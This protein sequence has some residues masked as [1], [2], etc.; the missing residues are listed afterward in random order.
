MIDWDTFFA[1][2]LGASAGLTGL[3]FVGISINMSQ[4]IAFPHL[5]NR[6]LQA[7]IV[8][9]TILLV[10]SLLLVPGQ[11]PAELGAEILILGIVVS[12]MVANISIRSLRVVGKEHR[13]ATI[14]EALLGQLALLFYIAAGI[15]L[16]TLGTEGIYLVVPAFLTSFVNAIEDAWVLLV[17]INR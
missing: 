13:W 1:A 2:Q 15:V 14:L 5:A 9:V 17:E 4:I 12:A 3:L 11:S 8:L 10:S 16:L 6:A 7:L